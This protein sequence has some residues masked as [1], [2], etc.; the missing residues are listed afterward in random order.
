M[1]K[2]LRQTKTLRAGCSK[3]QPKIFAPPETPF[4][5]VQDGQ[6]FISWR[7]SLPLPTNPVWW[8]SMHSIS[9]YRGNRPTH[10]HTHTKTGPITTYCA[11]ASAQCNQEA[12]TNCWSIPTQFDW[13][14]FIKHT[15]PTHTH[16]HTQEHSSRWNTTLALRFSGHFPGEPGLASV[17][18][19]KGWWRWWVVT[20]G[21]LEL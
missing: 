5:G 15:K 13:L 18:W 4:P 1:K 8:R 10:T 14:I 19:S 11:T 17:Y 2:V 16:T 9:S 12:F 21:L 20:T 7:W 6:N 3:A